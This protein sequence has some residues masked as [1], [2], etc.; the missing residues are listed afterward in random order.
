MH[1][2]KEG[3]R[4]PD[5]CKNIHKNCKGTEY[6]EV[7]GNISPKGQAYLKGHDCVTK[8]GRKEGKERLLQNP[9][10]KEHLKDH[11]SNTPTNT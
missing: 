8:E 9:Q 1:K 6:V 4:S 7:G 11:H 2:L 5:N 3:F 10:P